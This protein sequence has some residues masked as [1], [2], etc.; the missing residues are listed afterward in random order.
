MI[1]LMLKNHGDWHGLTEEDPCDKSVR[2]VTILIAW[3][4]T[5][6]IAEAEDVQ[7]NASC[8]TSSIDWEQDRPCYQTADE[9]NRDRDLQI[10]KEEEAIERL[11]VKNIAVR[12]LVEGSNPVEQP[13]RQVWGSLPQRY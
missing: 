1:S 8:A 11:V 9:A 5:L 4:A 10:S 7:L 6:D 12:D 2:I 3:N 13:F